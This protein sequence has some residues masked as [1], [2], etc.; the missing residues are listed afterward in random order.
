MRCQRFHSAIALAV[1][2]VVAGTARLS[3]QQAFPAEGSEADLIAVLQS[4]APLF[5]KAKACQRLAVIGTKE[6]VPVL[7]GLLADAKLAHYAR[8]ALEP[9]PDPAVD[10][11]LEAALNKLDGKLLVGA[12]NS[13]GVRGDARAVG[14]LEELM[15][16]ADSGVA[17]AAAAAL[18]RI[19]SPD[20][21]AALR[22]AL[23]KSEPLRSAAAA[24]CLVAADAM[25]AADKTGDAE[26]LFD[27]VRKAEV[28][29][30]MHMAAL[31]GA[32]RAQGAAAMP[33]LAQC[34][35]SDSQ[36]EFRVGLQM[37]HKLG[38]PK[39]AGLVMDLVELPGPVATPK[40]GTV[41]H[42]AE[43]GA[44][45][46]W[47]D[48][49]AAATAA[50]ASGQPIVASNTLAGDPA[51]GVVKSLRIVYSKDGEQTSVELA[52]GKEL[53]LEGVVAGPQYPRQVTLI[54]VLGDLGEKTALP[55]VLKAAKCDAADIRQAAIVV[56]G[57]LGDAS[58][59][60]VLL[61]AA[62]D[63][64]L[65]AKQS[66]IDLQAEGVDAAL[67]DALAGAEGAKRIVLL[68][69]AGDRAMTELAPA[70]LKA[71]D[72]ADPQIAKTAITALGA[73][74]GLDELPALIARVTGSDSADL[75]A[76]A[77]DALKVALLRTA[78]RDA[79]AE[80]LLAAMP[81]ASVKNQIDLLELLG[82]LGGERALTGVAAAVRSG[83]DEIQDAATRVLGEW[84]SP[85]VAPVLL[86]LAQT[87][88]AKYRV[89]C[90]RGYVRAFRQL[91]LPDADKMTM[92]AKAFDAATRDDERRLA[93]EALDRIP[94]PK[95]LAMVM[96]H[97]DDPALKA[98]V[99]KTAVA[100]AERT[101]AAHPA[102]VAEAMTK[103]LA[104]NPDADTA[105]KAR[106]WLNEAKGR[107]GNN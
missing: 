81:K 37:A 68:Q 82:V 29:Q 17:T 38:G 106:R 79:A 43:Y 92:A 20:A 51:P 78:D 96:A 65:A 9:I 97:L 48:V 98:T 73:T 13:V 4:D 39:V 15:G 3:A 14:R 25:L 104:T 69:L 11:T 16:N 66:L 74:V 21:I 54:R 56:L 45:D 49:T 19:A 70:L 27:A 84:M 34:L 95:A 99:A 41:I 67:A 40:E 86:D 53:V 31:T 42:K 72:D 23:K 46:R 103:V 1:L 102:V 8:Y 26:A 87:G 75:A 7:A 50:A 94:D 12:I 33:L 76:A 30:Y 6:S 10:E 101:V 93:L 24:A 83:N 35:K 44:G 55:V 60:P 47:A 36:A 62:A 58:A 52:E 2:F 63:G 59:V 91:G 85:D 107:L 57:G 28:P 5:D 71:A 89:R 18:G 90:L 100:I 61:E 32:M 22:E 64:S 88:P 105:G 77:K 80:K